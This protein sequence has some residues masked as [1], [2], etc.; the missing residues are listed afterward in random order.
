M[1][2][3]FFD[4]SKFQ[5][6]KKSLASK[7]SANGL[8]FK[9]WGQCAVLI[10]G[11]ETPVTVMETPSGFYDIAFYPGL[12]LSGLISYIREHQEAGAKV[13]MEYGV[14]A[15]YVQVDCRKVT[16]AEDKAWIAIHTILQKLHSF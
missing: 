9:M 3:M 13:P 6:V 16:E 7:L 8:R 4:P 15:I 14:N 11:S 1:A 5:L 10:A 2:Q 12:S